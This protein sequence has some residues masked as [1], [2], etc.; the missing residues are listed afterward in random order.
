MEQ[1]NIL[2][3]ILLEENTKPKRHLVISVICIIYFFFLALAIPIIIVKS[4]T[5]TNWPFLA[6]VAYLVIT[7]VSIIGIWK[8]KKWGAIGF[9]ALTGIVQ[10]IIVANG[11][12]SLKSLLIPTICSIILLVQIKKMK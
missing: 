5:V 3:P 10:A 4:N 8:M 2:D 12:W 11:N 1:E 6:M 9:I 7:L